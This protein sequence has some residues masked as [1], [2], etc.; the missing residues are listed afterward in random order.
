MK[1]VISAGISPVIV[2]PHDGFI[3]CFE[4]YGN[5]FAKFGHEAVYVGL[6]AVQQNLDLILNAD[7]WISE[8]NTFYV[9][10]YLM[11]LESGQIKGKVWFVQHGSY[12]E[13]DSYTHWALEAIRKADAV[14]VN[15]VHSKRIL[16][17]IIDTPVYD[18]IPQPIDD[19]LFSMLSNV[20]K[21]DRI[22]IGHVGGGDLYKEDPRRHQLLAAAVFR[23][24][25]L[26]LLS[27]AEEYNAKFSFCKDIEFSAP[28]PDGIEYYAFLASHKY[29]VSISS[30][31]TLG[32]DMILAAVSGTVSIASPYYYQALL[33]PST[34]A[35]QLGDF[36]ELR[37][38]V[39]Q[40]N[41]NIIKI[42]QANARNYTFSAVYQ[43]VMEKL[44]L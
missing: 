22:L 42:A 43:R 21:R 20:E 8:F 31:P 16:S 7:L 4:N 23:D 40:D 34:T 37:R 39:G 11:I 41:S 38:V 13:F 15:T 26:T 19:R 14:I 29:F 18:D 9:P 3:N 5:M 28:K 24:Y 17:E 2:Y 44:S 30:I 25:P 32:R 33:F 1:V 10:L 36:F 35:W 27:R 6:P 12:D